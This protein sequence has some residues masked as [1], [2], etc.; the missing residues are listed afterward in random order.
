MFNR[1][2][3]AI[4]KRELREKLLSKTFVL[5]T[6]LLPIFMFGILGIQTF[7]Y[8]VGNKTK[9]NLQILSNSPELTSALK[10]SF[11]NKNFVKN[12]EIKIN[13]E[14]VHKEDLKSFL[15][16][17]KPGLL[18]NKLTGIVFIPD[19]SLIN[20]KIEYFSK[21]PNNSSLF[22]KIKQPINKALI[23]V[24]FKNQNL[25]DSQ[26]SFA[27]ENVGVNGFLISSDKGI[28]KAGMGNVVA[29]FL[30]TFLLYISLLMIGTM[31]MRS[32]VQEKSNRI[33]EVLLSSA[34][35]TELMVGKIL[36]NS[37]TGII[38]MFIWLLP[39]IFIIST[40]WFMLPPDLTI[41][42][43][44]GNILFLL[45]YYFIGL[46]TFLGLFA[47]VG[48]IFDND[49][50]AQSGTWPILM[51]IMIPFFIAISLNNN[52]Q[53]IIA[54]VSSMLPFCAIIVMPARMALSEVPVI[55]IVIS[56]VVSLATLFAIFPVAGRIYKV[57]ILMSGKKPKW[58]EVIKWIKTA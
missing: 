36:G 51:L 30:I 29:S 39:L 16:K 47:S 20:K 18:N 40:S 31:V 54:V 8:S 32:V 44:M 52:P 57:G 48:A 50:D 27:R 56:I 45:L 9:S 22:N 21:N 17:S 28:Q 4:I 11:Q 6:L 5:M 43:T 15:D 55:Q 41:S 12:G 37:I 19:S 23:G 53:N 58:S 26:L 10:K 34:S 25:S 3:Y 13:F 24:Y 7:I 14:T 2:T 35:S 46:V 49:Q 33:V 38:Q 1:R 42:I